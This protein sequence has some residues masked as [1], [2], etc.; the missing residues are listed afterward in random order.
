MAAKLKEMQDAMSKPEIQ[1]QMAEMQAYM[2][3]QQVQQRM[4][5]RAGWKT[6]Y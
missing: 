5:V 2:Q 6:P 3:N 1:Q 4:Q